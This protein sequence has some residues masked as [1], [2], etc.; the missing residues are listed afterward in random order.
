MVVGLPVSLDGE[1]H[2][3]GQRIQSF[4]ERL[5]SFYSA[6]HSFSGMSAIQQLKHNV[7]LRNQVKMER[8]D[9]RNEVGGGSGKTE[10]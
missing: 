8:A 5:R 1:I 4:A 7:S 9:A 10:A 2:M 3:Q 6:F